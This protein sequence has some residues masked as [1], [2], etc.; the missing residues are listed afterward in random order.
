MNK[1][2]LFTLADIILIVVLLIISSF[3]ILFI[4]NN[5]NIKKIQIFKHNQ[6]IGEY[7]LNKDQ[8]IKIDQNIIAEIKAN[9]VRMKESNCKNQYCVKQSWT[10]SFPIVCVPNEVVIKIISKKKEMLITR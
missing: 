3:L 1:V 5:T 9:K 2:K 8:I 6:L 10:D 4:N 7:N